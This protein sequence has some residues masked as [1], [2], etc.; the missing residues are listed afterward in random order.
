MSKWM[1]VSCG[2]DEI[3]DLAHPEIH[4]FDSVYDEPSPGETA[5]AIAGLLGPPRRQPGDWLRE[6]S[7]VLIP[8]AEMRDL[9]TMRGSVSYK[10]VPPSATGGDS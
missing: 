7:I 1:I 5:D 10:R 9:G 3:S 2:S 6:S 8:L 4:V